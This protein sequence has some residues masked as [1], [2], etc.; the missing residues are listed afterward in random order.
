MFTFQEQHLKVSHFQIMS[1]TLISSVEQGKFKVIWEQ[2]ENS[3]INFWPS[4]HE[5]C[6]LNVHESHMTPGIAELL[7][8]HMVFPSFASLLR[9]LN[10]TLGIL[11]PLAKQKE[12]SRQAWIHWMAWHL[13]VGSWIYWKLAVP[14]EIFTLDIVKFW[15]TTDLWDIFEINGN[16]SSYSSVGDGVAKIVL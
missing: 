16:R 7:L 11:N 4:H 1:D 13:E 5:H 12:T 3:C 8:D 14:T 15:K 2:K 6:S 10:T 9:A